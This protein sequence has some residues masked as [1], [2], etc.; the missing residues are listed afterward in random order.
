MKKLLSFIPIIL[1]IFTILVYYNESFNSLMFS[2]M[3]VFETFIPVFTLNA[4]GIILAILCL[5]KYRKDT[6]MII[7]II[8]LILNLIPII[9]YIPT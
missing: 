3:P 8:G 7:N 2:L 4:I 5:I 6:N 1:G 9:S